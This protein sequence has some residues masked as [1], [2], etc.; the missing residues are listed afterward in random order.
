MRRLPTS[1]L[2]IVL[3]IAS[4]TPHASHFRS[5]CDHLFQPPAHLRGVFELKVR[6]NSK[7]DLVSAEVASIS[8]AA[9]SSSSL[10]PL[11][12]CMAAHIDFY[13]LVLPHSPGT[14]IVP[15]TACGALDSCE[16]P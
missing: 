16:Q 13:R 11:A 4:T 1:F 10:L 15:V 12:A 5:P 3:V 14:H 6:N 7:G 9:D 2:A 8:T